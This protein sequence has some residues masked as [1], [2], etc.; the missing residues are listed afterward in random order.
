MATAGEF[1][2][3]ARGDASL[4]CEVLTGNLQ[5]G[6][7]LIPGIKFDSPIP[8]FK[9]DSRCSQRVSFPGNA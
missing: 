9:N 5:L 2:R 1:Q 7:V 6:P 8:L 4:H 3:R